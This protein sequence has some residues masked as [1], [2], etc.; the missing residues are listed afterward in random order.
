LPRRQTQVISAPTTFSSSPSATTA[1]TQSTSAS[2]SS[3]PSAT[4]AASTTPFD[5][6][7]N[8]S[9][10]LLARLGNVLKES[11]ESN[12]HTC[13]DRSLFIQDLILS[14]LAMGFSIDSDL[15]SPTTNSD[16]NRENS[17]PNDVPNNLKRADSGTKTDVVKGAAAV[18]ELATSFSPS[19][20][21]SCSS[22]SSTSSSVEVSELRHLPSSAPSSALLL[23]ESPYKGVS[24]TL[25]NNLSVSTRPKQSFHHNEAKGR[26]VGGMRVPSAS[27]S[28]S[29][30]STS[31]PSRASGSSGGSSGSATLGSM[32]R[33]RSHATGT[34]SSNGAAASSSPTSSTSSSSSST[35]LLRKPVR[36]QTSHP[37]PPPSSH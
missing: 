22:S 3:A 10:L 19:F 27:S 28:S 33:S 7:T 34:T 6:S 26:R 30:S 35:S 16:F 24:T 5:S 32:V 13:Q 17:P 14:T 12:S 21:S 25:A 11:K 2:S 18:D 31:S 37:P 36:P 8:N 15:S 20:S 29:T 1:A 9:Q 23:P 4:H